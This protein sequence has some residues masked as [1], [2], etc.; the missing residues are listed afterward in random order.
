M[1]NDVKQNDKDEEKEKGGA[2]GMR[3]LQRLTKRIVSVPKKEIDDK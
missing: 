3:R 2:E 1:P